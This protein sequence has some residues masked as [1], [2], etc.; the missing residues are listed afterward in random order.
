MIHKN[1]SLM[2]HQ[3]GSL[4]WFQYKMIFIFRTHNSSN[5]R[6]IDRVKV[7][8]LVPDD[9]ELRNKSSFT[10]SVDVFI[11]NRIMSLMIHK[12]NQFKLELI[13]SIT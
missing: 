6:T 3:F 2:I 13:K 10:K 5:L 11:K 9:F 8:C 1:S 7:N 4:C 12:L